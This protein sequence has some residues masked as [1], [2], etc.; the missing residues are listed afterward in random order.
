MELSRGEHPD[1]ERSG[2]KLADMMDRENAEMIRHSSL[3]F[4]NLASHI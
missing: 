2:G 3:G 4:D 1:S